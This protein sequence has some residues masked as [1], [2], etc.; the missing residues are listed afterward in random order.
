MINTSFIRL[1]VPKARAYKTG[2]KLY[3]FYFN[4]RK[5]CQ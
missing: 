2:T 4:I 5:K 3:D 1:K